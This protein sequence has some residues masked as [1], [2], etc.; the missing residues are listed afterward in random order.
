MTA[1][2]VV[3][4]GVALVVVALT[5]LFGPWGLLGSGLV[6]MVAGLLVDLEGV[7]RG[8]S[9]DAPAPSPKG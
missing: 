4:V 6:L 7:T 3:A 9:V 2:R 5:W 8:E 1:L